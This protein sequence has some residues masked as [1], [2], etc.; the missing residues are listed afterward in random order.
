MPLTGVAM[1][2]ARFSERQVSV[3]RLKSR[4][5]AFSSINRTGFDGNFCDSGSPVGMNSAMPESIALPP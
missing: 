5:M 3:A 1:V 4:T 2:N